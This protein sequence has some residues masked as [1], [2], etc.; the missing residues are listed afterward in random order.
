[1]ELLRLRACSIQQLMVAISDGN[2]SFNRSKNVSDRCRH[3]HG[4]EEWISWAR[5][6]PKID[7]LLTQ[8]RFDAPGHCKA[9]RFRS[10]AGRPCIPSVIIRWIGAGLVKKDEALT[11][12]SLHHLKPLCGLSAISLYP[13]LFLKTRKMLLNNKN[14]TSKAY[15]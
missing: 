7:S 8:N 15:K 6:E 5:T 2:W 1:M 10:R 3:P 11:C 9:S 13:F 4:K 12:P 14:T